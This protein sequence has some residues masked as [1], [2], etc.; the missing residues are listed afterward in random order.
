MKTYIYLYKY[1]YIYIYTYMYICIYSI[2]IYICIYTY[3]YI[4]ICM[5]I[6]IYMCMYACMYVFMHVL[7]CKKQSIATYAC[8]VPIGG[9][10]KIFL[11]LNGHPFLKLEAIFFRESI[12]TWSQYGSRLGIDFLIDFDGFWAP[13][14]ERK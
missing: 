10:S 8:K 9:A 13:S 14:W 2:Y 11:G 6:Y 4:Y 7:D 1:I 12:Q 3:I 5:Y